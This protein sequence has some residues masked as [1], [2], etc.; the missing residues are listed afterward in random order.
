MLQTF[1]SELPD[2]EYANVTS[3][4][5]TLSPDSVRHFASQHVISPTK[6][7][8]E[9]TVTLSRTR[10]DVAVANLVLHHVDDVEGFMSGLKGLLSDD[11]I[12]IFTEFT[13]LDHKHKV[14]SS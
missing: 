7:E 8:P 14:R 2:I 6:A 13:N 12:V 3:S 10:W 9:R 11:G 5:H 4:L 1:A